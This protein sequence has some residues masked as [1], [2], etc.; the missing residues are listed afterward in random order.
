MRSRSQALTN[1]ALI[2]DYRSRT[3]AGAAAAPKTEQREETVER[4]PSAAGLIERWQAPVVSEEE[5][6][7]WAARYRL[8]PKS[9]MSFVEYLIVRGVGHLS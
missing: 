3:T 4:D 7:A 6:E 5:I 9:S 2:R 8:C 1:V